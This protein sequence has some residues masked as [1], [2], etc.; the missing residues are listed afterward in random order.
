MTISEIRD[1]FRAKGYDK[2]TKDN[3]LYNGIY[4]TIK[5]NLSHFTAVDNN[6]WTLTDW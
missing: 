1:E 5:R 2:E 3:I 6:R 4:T